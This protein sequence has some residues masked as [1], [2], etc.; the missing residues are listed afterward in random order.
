M[1]FKEILTRL[2]TGAL[3]S[4][5]IFAVGPASG[6]VVTR[7]AVRAET[8]YAP[9][10]ASNDATTNTVRKIKNKTQ[11]GI[12]VSYRNTTKERY[13]HID[14]E[15]VSVYPIYTIEYDNGDVEKDQVDKKA[16]IKADDLDIDYGILFDK[17]ENEFY[18]KQLSTGFESKFT[19]LGADIVKQELSGIYATYKGEGG[20][21]VG[22][23]VPYYDIDVVPE[24]KVTYDNGEIAYENDYTV[25]CYNFEYF[26]KTLTKDGENEI[27]LEY[28][29]EGSDKK[30]ST[31][32]MLSAKDTGKTA[33]DEKKNEE[34][35]PQVNTEGNRSSIPVYVDAE[36]H[37]KAEEKVKPGNGE[38]PED[39]VKPGN[40]EKPEE[41]V[42][43]DSGEKS[44][45]NI[46]PEN[47]DKPEKE[48]ENKQDDKK[49]HNDPDEGNRNDKKPAA[50]SERHDESQEDGGQESDSQGDD[51][52]NDGDVSKDDDSDA[53]DGDGSGKK[54]KDK[55]KKD[56]KP[57][58]ENDSSENEDDSKDPSFISYQKYSQD[59]VTDEDE[60]VV[61]ASKKAKAGAD[62]GSEKDD[63]DKEKERTYKTMATGVVSSVVGIGLMATGAFRYLWMLLLTLF[64]KKKRYKW[65]GILSSGKNRFVEVRDTSGSGKLYQDYIDEHKDLND[66]FDEIGK[67]N[68]YTLLPVNTKA[69][70][71]YAND[72]ISVVASEDEVFRA[73][74]NLPKGIGK[75]NVRIYNDMARFE[76]PLTFTL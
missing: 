53:N 64:T 14:P 45:E 51:N 34:D 57:S 6:E 33:S 56:S 1:F 15:F 5:L 18:A 16:C 19:V 27:K 40:E 67:S 2:C 7:T 22:D 59:A 23:K 48:P 58:A 63:K 72:C 75:V 43:P 10:A 47:E 61:T 65:H 25:S 3:S 50:D 42:K 38:K 21:K 20:L 74:N 68:D 26:P 41:S 9:Q 37:D 52:G 11:T 28:T 29:P 39:S 55:K 71:S 66:I 54:K 8:L 35:N 62:R 12:E 36:K 60:D 44:E 31:S 70:I 32:I 73:L 30:L 46:K 4:T 24:Y 13:S 17:G 69:D 76:M 49:K